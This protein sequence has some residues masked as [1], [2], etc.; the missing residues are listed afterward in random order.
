MRIVAMASVIRRRALSTRELSA[1]V[2]DDRRCEVGPT[3]VLRE[4]N[5]RRD[6]HADRLSRERQSEPM[7]TAPT[8]SGS[9]VMP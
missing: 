3:G 1:G 8:E 6:E 7:M 9:R 4:R 2:E 5:V